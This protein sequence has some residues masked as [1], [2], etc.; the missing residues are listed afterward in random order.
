VSDAGSGAALTRV[1]IDG[2]VRAATLLSVRGGELVGR[3]LALRQATGRGL[4]ADGGQVDLE[5]VH[6][7]DIR[8]SEAA[9]L[10]ASGSSGRLVHLDVAQV[11]R[12]GLLLNRDRL[13]ARPGVFEVRDVR[14]SGVVRTLTDI[15]RDV[16]GSGAGVVV[17]APNTVTLDGLRTELTAGPGLLALDDGAVLRGGRVAVVDSGNLDGGQVDG[18]GVVIARGADAELR[19]VRVA[20]SVA[21]GLFVSEARARVHSLSVQ[22]VRVGEV[23]DADSATR[24]GEG[25]AAVDADLEVTQFRVVDATT[26][27]VLVGRGEA[28][29]ERG[30][31]LGTRLLRQPDGG[32]FAAGVLVLGGRTVVADVGLADNAGPGVVA[33]GGASVDLAGLIVNDPAKRHPFAYG[34]VSL[35]TAQVRVRDSY[36]NYP[37]FAGLL[38]VSGTLEAHNLSIG[39]ARPGLESDTTYCVW[40]NDR[41]VVR[42]SDVTLVQCGEVAIGA[43]QSTVDAERVA[44]VGE[45]DAEGDAI[46]ADLDSTVTLRGFRI[47]GHD[48]NGL[49]VSDSAATLNGGWIVANATAVLR[50]R[51]STV[52]Q[53]AVRFLA[54]DKDE[55]V[56]SETCYERPPPVA[57]IQAPPPPPPL[58]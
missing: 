20:R 7:R 29:L 1:A 45:G 31:I 58:Q 33:G 49:V 6:V 56:C 35:A 39:G 12:V 32:L 3:D 41:G 50:Q 52:R 26:A 2:A 17:T 11:F 18:G 38:A 54:N 27:G 5:R 53:T 24:D 8:G 43:F 13:G 15:A 4:S 10:Q 28:R 14:I 57:T 23:D 40:A 30:A 48:G 42:L 9:G 47:E 51:I 34:I 44:I 22:D 55:V 25:I 16:G 36:V 46:Y 19:D 21:Q 37:A